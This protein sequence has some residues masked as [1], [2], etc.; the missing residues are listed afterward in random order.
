VYR[1]DLGQLKS[2]LFLNE[3]MTEDV[4][5]KDCGVCLNPHWEDQLDQSGLCPT[6]SV[7][8]IE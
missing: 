8:V 4:E 6:C 7:D 1:I 5:T 3:K 2:F